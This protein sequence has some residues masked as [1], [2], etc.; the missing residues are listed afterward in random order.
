MVIPDTQV[1]PGKSVAFLRSIGHYMIH[2]RPDVVVM[3]GDFTDMES[4]SSWDKGKKSFEGRRYKADVEAT[5]KAQEALL[6]PLREHNLEQNAKGLP[7]Y[8]PKLHMLLGNHEDRIDRAVNGQAEFEGL[9]STDDLKYAEYGWEVHPFLEVLVINGVAF[10]HY[11]TTGAMQRPAGT[12][13]AL[14]TKRQMSC[15]AGHQQ[16]RQI[17][18]A[19]KANGRINTAI[20][21]GSC[22]QEDHRVLTAE[23]DYVPLKGVK[24][25]TRL[26]SFEETRTGLHR[27]RRYLTGTVTGAR[28]SVRPGFEVTLSDGKMFKVTG[29]HRWLCRAEGGTQYAWKT[30]DNLQTTVGRR[31]GTKI[32][33]LL[34]EWERLTNYDAGWCSG[35]YD[36]E[37]SLYQRI[38][39][40]G[41][42]GTV[43]LSLSQKEGSTSAQIKRRLE[44]VCGVGIAKETVTE[45]DILNFR[46]IGGIRNTV[47]VLGQLKPMRLISKFKPE[48]MGILTTKGGDFVNVVS[49]VP[50]GD[51]TVREL[52]IDE[53]TMIVEGFGHHNCYEHHE[54]YL[55]P[56]GNNHWRGFLF[57][58]GV[59]QGEFYEQW[60]SVEHAKKKFPER[61][62]RGRKPVASK[63]RAK[64]WACSPKKEEV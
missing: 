7:Q 58:H 30:T 35:M 43:Q 48:G 29:D 10:S 33:K 17:A 39:P 20:I 14:L 44:R 31:N 28:S 22:L 19:V 25:G 56:Q 26:V 8:V 21:A 61:D 49:V 55:G 46:V 16:G 24:E 45:R 37:G 5:H 40:D 23:L 2:K 13:A 62:P 63:A 51:I 1:K 15:V 47:K 38:L 42:M 27:G 64:V 12:A 41:R 50:C 34:P 11:F 9:L 32:P 36:G 3:L 59:D 54:G 57:L 6:G 53:G 52:D 18:T 60:I 4:L